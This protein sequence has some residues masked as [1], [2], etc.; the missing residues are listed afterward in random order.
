MTTRLSLVRG[1]GKFVDDITLP[2][3]LHMAV[4]RSPHARATVLSVEGGMNADTLHARIGGFGEGA[5]ADVDPATLHPVFASD[6]VYYVGQPVAAVCAGDR[7]VA[8]DKLDEINVE[9]EKLPPIMTIE[10]ALSSPPLHAGTPSNILKQSWIG[11]DFDDP[12]TSVVLEDEFVIDRIVN[13][14]LEPRGI[15]ADYDGARLTVWISTQSVFSIKRGLCNTLKLKSSAVRV[16]Q[17]D[18]GG[19]FGVKSALYPEYVM[20]A[21]A[22]LT[23]RRPVKWIESRS[24]HLAASQPGRGVRGTTKLFASPEGEVEALRAEVTTDAG[25]FGGTAGT[26]SPFFIAMQLTGP[27]GI[28]KARVRATSVMT[29]KPPQGPYRGAG[30]PEAAFFIERMMDALADEVGKGADDVR[31]INTTTRRFVSPLGLE[32]EPSRPF[33]ER[34]LTELKY[35]GRSYGDQAG[36]S[37]FVLVPSV[38]PGESARVSVHNGTIDVWLGGNQHGQAHEAFVKRLLSEEL[39]I[40]KDLVT[41]NRGDSDMLAN[42][43]GTWGSRSA[44]LDGAAALAAAREVKAQVEQQHGTYTAQ[45][46]LEGTY[47]AEVFDEHSGQ[48]NSFGANLATVDIDA[49]GMV[50][51]KECAACY[52][53]G[54]ALTPGVVEGQIVGGT[55]QGIGQVLYES[56]VHDMAGRLLTKDLFDAGLP[57]AE[58]IPEFAITV[59]EQPSSFPHKAKG[60]G[61]AP[62]IGVPPAV[63]RAIENV[64]GIRIRHTPVSPAE[65]IERSDA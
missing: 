7:Y 40:S 16:I 42:G 53:V 28:K 41:L 37:F 38:T 19:A 50:T 55:L 18:T 60:L 13:N 43:I 14:P 33:L 65:L 3:M 11:A 20:A 56:V 64:S 61:E 21:H 63:V 51:V 8:E 12:P 32:I 39:G 47:N 59:V 25:A 4:A 23:Y 36:L 10:D 22:A 1:A 35:G 5:R 17:A 46:L 6:A 62:T 52:D 29:N 2:R 26:S 31:L 24:E 15:V 44:I 30:R 34:A 54:R 58:N 57:I 45:A 9:Y 49:F 27:Y 48:L